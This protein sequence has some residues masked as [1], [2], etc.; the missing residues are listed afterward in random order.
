MED[1][2]HQSNYETMTPVTDMPPDGA[3]EEAATNETPEIPDE[4]D[5]KD[6]PK[7]KLAL[8]TIGHFILSQSYVA[9]LIVM[10]VRIA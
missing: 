8:I 1:A 9:T 5:E 3:P 2:E 7:K 6:K 4:D 10:M